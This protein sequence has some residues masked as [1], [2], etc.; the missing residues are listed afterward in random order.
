[1]NR[2][3]ECPF[4][5][6]SGFNSM[7]SYPCP[8]GIGLNPGD[9]CEYLLGGPRCGA[10]VRDFIPGTTPL[11][12]Y[13][14]RTHHYVWSASGRRTAYGRHQYH[15]TAVIPLDHPTMQRGEL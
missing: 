3:L 15:L 6:G 14:D 9:I 10:T 11:P 1:M 13:T 12:H 2:E 5:D 4:C 8:T 7:A